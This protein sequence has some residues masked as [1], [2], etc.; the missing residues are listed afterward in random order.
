LHH[1]NALTDLILLVQVTVQFFEKEL[2]QHLNIQRAFRQLYWYELIRKSAKEASE[3]LGL[4]EIEMTK[5]NPYPMNKQ[6]DFKRRLGRRKVKAG[7]DNGTPG[8]GLE[9][10]RT[11]R[12]ELTNTNR[13]V[14][15]VKETEDLTRPIVNTHLGIVC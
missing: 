3:Q 14:N 10:T 13:K 11:S 12:T 9:N 15:N 8:K 1:F 4:V 7:E 6:P 5:P 2:Y